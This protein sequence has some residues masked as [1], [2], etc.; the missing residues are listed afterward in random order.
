MRL[1]ALLAATVLSIGACSSDSSVAP[2][3]SDAPKPDALRPDTTGLERALALELARF[4]DRVRG[5]P[6][7]AE[8]WGD[9]GVLYEIH[10]VLDEAVV[11]Y[12]RA[13]ALDG[14]DFRWPF[15]LG[16]AK[17]I[18]RQRDALAH[19]E[20][21]LELNADYAPLACYLG[22]TALLLDDVVRAR[23]AFAHALQLDSELV[24]A[25]L[26]LAKVDLAENRL[27]DA[28]ERLEAALALG[29]R[30][31]EVH[32]L[33]AQ[34]Y[35]RVGDDEKLAE[36]ARLA[37]RTP[38]LEPLTDSL[39]E[40]LMLRHGVTLHWRRV[41]TEHY[42]RQN[43]L[44]S[45]ETEWANAISFDPRNPRT[46]IAA[47][48]AFLRV[49]RGDLALGHF[50]QALVLDGASN[51]AW[52]G[53][54]KALY[55]QGELD[56]AIAAVEKALELD[57]TQHEARIDLG[58]MKLDKGDE[59]GLDLIRASCDALPESA[60]AHYRLARA[61]ATL[62]RP[63]AAL[64]T[65]RAT[66]DIDPTHVE[67]HHDYGTLLFEADRWTEAAQHYEQVCALAPNDPAGYLR[68]GQALAAAGSADRAVAALQRGI[69]RAGYEPELLFGL[70][71]ILATHPDDAVRDGSRAVQ[72]AQRL[73][74][75]AQHADPEALQLLAAAH[76]EAGDFTLA[77]T[78]AKEAIRLLERSE[79][80]PEQRASLEEIR[81]RLARFEKSEPLR[82]GVK[83]AETGV[84]DR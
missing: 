83:R 27:E 31:A 66:L 54:S 32:G 25:Y 7:S 21:A 62:G 11:C 68:L 56:D 38:V 26:G 39:R 69:D 57:P 61:Y 6:K 55:A 84:R 47:G 45:I 51:P 79:D 29:P 52:I 59:G 2:P 40:E 78:R 73:N 75:L 23:S 37:P 74:S 44:A 77:V 5:D 17:Q 13:Q 35:R 18:G 34:A 72:L 8:A 43:D 81:E 58:A 16:T 3:S 1:A 9:L 24:A 48:H 42:R 80:T 60:D 4:I 70:A 53:R 49:G 36:H 63:T 71:W 10:D 46:H 76:A 41:R 15:F 19:F 14:E 33:L 22:T 28:I 67:A 30:T 82:D 12:E 50:D 64:E 65:M 20:R